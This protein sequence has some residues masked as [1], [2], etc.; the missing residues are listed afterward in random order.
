MEDGLPDREL[1]KTGETGGERDENGRFVKGVSGNPAGRPK[2]RFRAGSRAA[3]LLLDDNME[4]LMAL[5]IEMGFA[6]DAVMVRDCLRKGIG[7][8]RGQPLVLDDVGDFP[9][10]SGPGDVPAATAT[11]GRWIGEGRVTPEEALHLTQA[12]G[13]PAVDPARAEPAAEEGDDPLEELERRLERMAQTMAEDAEEEAAER[14]KAGD[15]EAAAMVAAWVK[16]AK[17]PVDA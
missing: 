9:E 16:A 1:L 11:I 8:R 13:L 17:E 6:G 2:G 14:A 12:L 4:G 3:A 15:A 10:V 5:A 7:T